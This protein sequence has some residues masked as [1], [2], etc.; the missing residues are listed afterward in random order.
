[1]EVFVSIQKRKRH[2]EVK[3]A[4]RVASLLDWAKTGYIEEQKQSLG[5][6]RKRVKDLLSL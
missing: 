3:H 1:M 6:Q 5:H 4:L 2:E